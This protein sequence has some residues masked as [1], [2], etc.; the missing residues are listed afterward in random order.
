MLLQTH[1]F[2][3]EGLNTIKPEEVVLFIGSHGGERIRSCLN[4]I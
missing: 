2:E 1:S 4:Y 3:L